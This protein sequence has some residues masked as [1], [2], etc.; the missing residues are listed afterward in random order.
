ML[1]KLTPLH[2]VSKAGGEWHSTPN[3]PFFPDQPQVIVCVQRIPLTPVSAGILSIFPVRK[4][5][6]DKSNITI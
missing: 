4:S 2:C 5:S 6:K 3:N 1:T